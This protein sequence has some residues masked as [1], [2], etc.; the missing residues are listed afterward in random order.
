MDKGKA[1]KLAA[2]SPNDLSRWVRVVL[3]FWLC[4]QRMFGQSQHLVTG[5]LLLLVGSPELVLNWSHLTHCLLGETSCP[6]P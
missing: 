5:L 3:P 6:H 2:S 4:R 1:G